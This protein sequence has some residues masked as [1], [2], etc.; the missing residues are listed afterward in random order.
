MATPQKSCLDKGFKYTTSK[1]VGPDYL[2]K[3]FKR[4][5][6]EQ[7]RQA[8]EATNVQPINVR[9]RRTA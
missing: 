9:T 6:A 8:A 4:I 3:K 5:M 1:D 2:A 7:R